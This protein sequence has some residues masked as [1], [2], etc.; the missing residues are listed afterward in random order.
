MGGGI[1]VAL[2]QAAAADPWAQHGRGPRLQKMFGGYRSQDVWT[3]FRKYRAMDDGNGFLSFEEMQELLYFEDSGLLFIWDLYSQQNSLMDAKV[4][5]TIVCLFSGAMLVDKVRFLA[6]L[7]DGSSRGLCTG[8]EI[9]SLCTTVLAA[10]GK[11]TGCMTKAKDVVPHIQEELIQ[12]V[13]VCA[14]AAANVGAKQAFN[15]ERVIGQ[16]EVDRYLVPSVVEAYEQ[17]PLAIPVTAACPP[18]PPD[19]GT[20]GA[21]EVMPTK[22]STLDGKKDA[23]QAKDPVPA[24]AVGSLPQIS[25][26]SRLEADS[27]AYPKQTPRTVDGDEEALVAHRWIVM[28]GMQFALIAKG[29]AAFHRFFVK[30]VCSALGLPANSNC[31]EVLNVSNGSIVVEFVLRPPDFGPDTRTALVLAQVL[32]AQL[33]SPY[34]AL[35]RGPLGSFIT[36]AVM[37]QAEPQ[38]ADAIGTMAA[39]LLS[40]PTPKCEAA[41]TWEVETQTDT[42]MF[43]TPRAAK[44]KLAGTQ[45]ACPVAA[46][47]EASVR[48]RDAVRQL[49]AARQRKMRAEASR[50]KALEEASRL[51]A[52]IAELSQQDLPST[53]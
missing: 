29:V 14:Q 18:P 43:D 38:R 28:H 34:S 53:E 27:S 30:S 37:L 51:E 45:G 24:C 48:I 15:Q 31:V 47:E 22:K 20:T 19:W 36:N 5:L 2:L 52:L 35:R 39:G 42:T 6:T 11:C 33:G 46:A 21:K 12:L 8:A 7:F 44:A 41:V 50:Q 40:P 13:P 10:L 23:G 49:E 26:L 1:S 16:V 4:L 32:E 17:L 9:A 25:F 3:V